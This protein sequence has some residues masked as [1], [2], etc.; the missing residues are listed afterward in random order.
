MEMFEFTFSHPVLD[1][2]KHKSYF[3]EAFLIKNIY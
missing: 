3:Q 1:E 2:L